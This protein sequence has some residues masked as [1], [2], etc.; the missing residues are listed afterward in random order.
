MWVS[1]VLVSIITSW[2]T[3]KIITLKY[4]DIL[5]GLSQDMINENKEAI[6]SAVDVIRNATGGK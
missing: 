6:K 2:L 4:L 1:V 3:T 5:E